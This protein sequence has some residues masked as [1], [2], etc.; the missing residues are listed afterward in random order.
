MNKK[1]ISFA[2]AKR[3][4]PHRYTLEHVPA[5]ASKPCEGN[6][7]FYAPQ[8]KSDLEWYERTEFPSPSSKED[9]CVSAHQS[10]PCGLWLDKPFKKSEFTLAA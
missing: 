3:M 7:K 5:W 8:Y 1:A 10:W 9:H 2:Q 6:G 4:Y